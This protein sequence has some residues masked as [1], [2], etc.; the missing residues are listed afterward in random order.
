[1]LNETNF[2]K[3]SSNFMKLV[4]MKKL[5]EV[6]LAERHLVSREVAG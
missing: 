3:F 5:H 6:Y 4:Q 1:M 2:M